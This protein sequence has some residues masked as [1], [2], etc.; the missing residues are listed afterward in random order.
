MAKIAILFELSFV[1]IKV[2]IQAMLELD[3]LILWGSVVAEDVAFGTR[4]GEVL[5]SEREARLRVIECLLVDLRALPG[6]SV[7][8]LKAVGAKSAVVLVLVTG[9]AG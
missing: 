7:M 9:R 4:C 1:R 2:A 5:P 3:A 8:A 6:S